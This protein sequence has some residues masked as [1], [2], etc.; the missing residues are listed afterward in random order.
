MTNNAPCDDKF[1]ASVS[2]GPYMLGKF[3][4]IP[5]QTKLAG[6]HVIVESCYKLYFAEA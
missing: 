5:F 2:A 1:V 3:T 6:L 4:S